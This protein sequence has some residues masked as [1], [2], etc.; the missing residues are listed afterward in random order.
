MQFLY[1][2]D[3][4]TF[5]DNESYEQFELNEDT[6]GD[7]MKY[8]KENEV[9]DVLIAEGLAIGVELPIFVQLLV[10]ETDP[11]VRGDTASGGSKPALLET[12]ASVQVPLFVEK[13]STLKIDTRTNTYVE[14][15]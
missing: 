3:F 8:L 4:F 2:G 15:V 14:R 13:G 9:C 10:T 7:V 6:V 1:K 5:M 11:G 12:G